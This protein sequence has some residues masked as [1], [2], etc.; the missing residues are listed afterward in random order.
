MKVDALLGVHGSSR[1]VEDTIRGTGRGFPP[2]TA[3]IMDINR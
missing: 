3:S 1:Q 2:L